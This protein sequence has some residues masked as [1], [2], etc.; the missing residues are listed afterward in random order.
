[1]NRT[2]TCDLYQIT[3]N[4]ILLLNDTVVKLFFRMKPL[5]DKYACVI[6]LENYPE[7]WV[8]TVDLSHTQLKLVMMS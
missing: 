8:N 2:H 6:I 7:K 3:N 1:M 5:V 4:L